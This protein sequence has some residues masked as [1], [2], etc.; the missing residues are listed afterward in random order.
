MTTSSPSPAP[1]IA[2][3]PEPPYFAVIFTSRRD[4]AADDGYLEA[5]ARMEELARTMPGYL[6][7]EAARGADGIGIGVSYWESEEAIANWRKQAEHREAQAM[8]VREWYEAYA[9]RIARV[10]RQNAM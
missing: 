2:P 5:A 8:G 7:F 3:L 1:G 10:E 4:P 6:G 9:I